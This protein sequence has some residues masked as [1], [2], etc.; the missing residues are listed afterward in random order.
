MDPKTRKD[1]A[2]NRQCQNQYSF[3]Q[4]VPESSVSVPN[5]AGRKLPKIS[6][7][8]PRLGSVSARINCVRHRAHARRLLCGREPLNGRWP[9]TGSCSSPSHRHTLASAGISTARLTHPFQDQ[10][11][12]CQCGK[13]IR[14]S[15]DGSTCNVP[16]AQISAPAPAPV[17]PTPAVASGALPEQIGLNDVPDVVAIPRAIPCHSLRLNRGIFAVRHLDLPGIFPTR[18]GR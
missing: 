17:A 11:R 1:L 18:A 7:F 5:S 13:N 16:V 12:R 15:I 10:P 3:C 14:A 6:H 4:L 2:R 8:Q 9:S